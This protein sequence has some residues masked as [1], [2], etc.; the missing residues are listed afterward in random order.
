[1]SR[2]AFDAAS[3]RLVPLELATAPTHA[4]GILCG[5]RDL[6]KSCCGP[7][8]REYPPLLRFLSRRGGRHLLGRVLVG[9]D[10][11]RAEQ[12]L[13]MDPIHVIQPRLWPTDHRRNRQF[14][15]FHG[16]SYLHDLD[17]ARADIAHP[18]RTESRLNQAW[19][20][21][22]RCE[23]CTSR[24]RLSFPGLR[25]RLHAAVHRSRVLITAPAMSGFDL[26]LW[27]GTTFRS[28]ICIRP[29]S[30]YTIG[31]HL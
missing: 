3:V 5:S 28:K 10:C 13:G 15:V 1:M 7:A 19:T 14:G 27:C 24:F 25:S 17:R 20:P 29:R 11:L 23:R 18:R 8:D 9:D 6:G 12:H 16:H 21:S 2:H 22:Q 4:C 26:V 30:H 31:L